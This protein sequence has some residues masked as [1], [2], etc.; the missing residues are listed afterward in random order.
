MKNYTEVSSWAKSLFKRMGFVKRSATIG[1]PETV[2]KKKD[3]ETLFL[4]QIADL[5]EE[6]NIPVSLVLNFD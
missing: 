5:V 1:R 2:Q 3:V 4:H 6:N